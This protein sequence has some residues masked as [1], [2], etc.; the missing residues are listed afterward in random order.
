[1]KKIALFGGAFNPIHRSHV[2]MAFYVS[3]LDI[4]DKTWIMPCYK[5]VYRKK[6]IDPEHRLNMCRLAIERLN[7]VTKPLNIEI[8]DFEI[9][10]KLTGKSYDI[11]KRLKKKYKYDFHI[12]IGQDNA[13]NIHD[14]YE[15]EKII[16][17]FP[18]I[19]FP[20]NI[21]RKSL[22]WYKKEP[23]M[24]LDKN[25]PTMCSTDIRY[26]I[27]INSNVYT[28]QLDKKVIKYI[29]ENNLYGYK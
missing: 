7:N 4:I 18:F 15:Y 10:N 21:Q 13:D 17:E 25:M 11:L 23:H 27:G 1:V 14:W 16:N 2:K 22:D 6:I 26:S 29:K 19:V 28:E 3:L 9:K 20:R 12:I 5:S 8:S 24:F